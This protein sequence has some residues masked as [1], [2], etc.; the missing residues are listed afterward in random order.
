MS[1][2]INFCL[3]AAWPYSKLAEDNAELRLDRERLLGV[4]RRHK[5]AGRSDSV[6][7]H[8]D[9]IRK[10]NMSQKEVIKRV[11]CSCGTFCCW[12]CRCWCFC[13]RF[14]QRRTNRNK[15]TNLYGRVPDQACPGNVGNPLLAQIRISVGY[16]YGRSKRL[17]LHG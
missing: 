1:V 5:E 11:C 9:R 8:R 12:F 2:S 10:R 17:P 4:V 3:F 7:A 6:A 14:R 13:S 15:L 16:D